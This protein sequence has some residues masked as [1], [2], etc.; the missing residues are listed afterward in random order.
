MREAVR[1]LSRAPWSSPTGTATA[2]IDFQD[3]TPEAY[4]EYQFDYDIETRLSVP[5][6]LPGWRQL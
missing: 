2:T 5:G 3:G 4:F 6:V 1:E